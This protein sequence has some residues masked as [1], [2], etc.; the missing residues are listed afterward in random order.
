MNNDQNPRNVSKTE[1]IAFYVF[2]ITVIL[3]PLAFFW[4]KFQ[5]I[6]VIKTFVISMGVII[7]AV[8]LAYDALKTK[9]LSLLPKSIC[10]TSVLLVISIIVSSILSLHFTKSFFG[11]GFELGSASFILLMFL[12]V[13]VTFQLVTKNKDRAIILYFG[14][15]SSYIVLFIVH[16]LRIIFGKDFMS[17]GYMTSLTTTIFGNW[18]ALATFSS[19]I[20]FI[21]LYAI[22]YLDLKGKMKI[23]NFVLLALSLVAIIIVGDY[24]VWSVLFLS[25]VAMLIVFG[26]TK[27]KKQKASGTATI[28]AILKSI[29]IV[30]IIGIL[31][32]FSLIKWGDKIV[33]PI[34]N[35]LE[36]NVSGSF[37]PWQ[38]T[39]AVTSTT[40]QNYP[41]FGVGS[42]NFSQAYSVYKPIIMNLIPEWNIEYV[43]GV[44]L[45]PTFITTYGIVGSILW[46]LLFVFYGIISVKILC[47]MPE[48][49]DKRFMLVSSFSI[50]TFLWLSAFV[51]VPTHV[52]LFFTAIV[53]AIFLALAVAYGL[54]LPRAFSPAPGTKLNKMFG[55]FASL[56]ILILVLWAVQFARLTIANSYVSKSISLTSQG[57]F[58]T[59]DSALNTALQFAKNDFVWRSKAELSVVI[60][61]KLAQSVNSNMSASTTQTIINQIG[62]VLNA[63]AGAAKKALDY[64]NKNYYNYVTIARVAEVAS[65]LKLPKAYEQAV[66]AYNSAIALNPLN[67]ILY[68]SL[69]TLEAKNG[70]YDDSLKE[71][72]RALQVKNN[73]LDA[74]FLLSQVYASK[75]DLQ[76]AI[77]AA[78]VATQLN[79]ENP[80]LWFQNGLL[81]YNARDFAGSA[82][83][84]A[85]AVKYQ[86]DYANAKYFLGLS[87]ARLGNSKDAIVQFEDLAKTNQDNQ[88][89]ALI[90]ANLKSGKSIFNDTKAPVPAPE[91][92]S[93]LPLKEK[94]KKQ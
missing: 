33:G 75:G 31:L 44:G 55:L 29:M 21:T 37:L 22:Q 66:A 38:Q 48:E 43:F 82:E 62:D 4:S 89:I 7:S 60:A 67:P 11:Y 36:V 10:M 59:A 56:A 52:N 86:S 54:I 2:L 83:A 30:P 68:Y 13:N 17:L 42:N 25:F 8:L 9:S 46:I 39:L 6:D 92:R 73:Y 26:I 58:E 57:S 72:G 84:F 45:I 87:L 51:T 3:S 32:T 93:T 47:K 77:T 35:K 40:I 12:A 23:A 78:S 64:D 53:L 15:I 76:N 16:L 63:G 28:P 94:E 41:L 70:K 24:R 85:M 65:S 1:N 69:A 18:F 90:L 20:L 5:S 91:K 49:K 71:L 80:V 61:Q 19:I 88:E 79:P 81:R 14:F 34:A 50:G 74:I 27:Y